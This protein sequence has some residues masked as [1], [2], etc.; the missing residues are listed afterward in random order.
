MSA[1]NK[2][3]GFHQKVQ[4]AVK[5]EIPEFLLAFQRVLKLIEGLFQLGFDLVEVVDLIFGGLQ[6]FAGLLVDLLHVLLLLVELVDQLI[7]VGDFVVQVA[8]LV[9]LGGLVLFGFLQTEFQVLNVLLEAADLLLQF[10]L[11]LEQLVAGIFLLR[12]TLLGV[13]HD[14]TIN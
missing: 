9:I 11:V 14:G 8:D 4:I 3:V 13:L 6:V 1:L 12:Q 10:L 7:L 2:T 5:T